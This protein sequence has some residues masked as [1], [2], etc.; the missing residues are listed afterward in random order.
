MIRILT[1]IGARPQFIKASSISKVI[2]EQY[3]DEISED[4]LHTGQHFDHNMSEIFFEE[5]KIPKPR[6]HLKIDGLNSSEQFAEMYRQISQILTEVEYDAVLVYGDTNSTLA[7]SMAASKLNIPIIHVEAGLRSFNKTM[8]EEIN[9]ILTD[10]CSSLLF[11]PT[12]TGIENLRAENI[13]HNENDESNLPAVYLTGDIMYDSALN[14]SDFAD[15]NASHYRKKFDLKNGFMLATIHRDFN[16]DDPNK[17][18]TILKGL[19]EIADQHKKDIVLPIHPRTKKNLERNEFSE[20]KNLII[21]CER[22]KC[23][24]PVSY[25]EMLFLEKNCD[26][27]FTD[28]GGVQKEAYFFHKKC[29]VLRPQTEWTEIIDAGCAVLA[30]QSSYEI[31]EKYNWLT[32]R[33]GLEWP[34]LFGNGKSAEFIVDKIKKHLK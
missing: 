26:F 19:K 23:I 33:E 7:G 30:H 2:N 1:V 24:D 16:S 12:K 25:P 5:L 3:K 17:L 10:H 18:H 34:V 4:L 28:S 11:S 14:F 27:V 8:P 29:M 32:S 31:A 6:F 9:R 20:S 22:L 15:K 13:E 21:S